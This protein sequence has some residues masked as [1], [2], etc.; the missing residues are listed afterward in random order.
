[1]WRLS[2]LNATDSTS[3]EWPTKLRV[4]SPELRSHRRRVESQ[5]LQ[6][7]VGKARK[8]G[9]GQ[10]EAF[11]IS[12]GPGQ[13]ELA[14]RGQHDVRDEVVVA[15]QRVLGQAVLLRLVEQLPDDQALVCAATRNR[16]AEGND[17]GLGGRRAPQHV[18]REPD[19]RKEA[20]CSVVAKQVTQL[21][22]PRSVP[23][24][25]KAS[26]DILTAAGGNEPQNA[27]NSDSTE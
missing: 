8:T 14:V 17:D 26:P 5:E 18:P 2:V 23:R 10:R 1:M 4:V 22:W 25:T 7:R 11:K 15:T 3:L 6:T 21:E 19:S 16:D 12:R 13:R 20:F 27:V 9:A 24:N